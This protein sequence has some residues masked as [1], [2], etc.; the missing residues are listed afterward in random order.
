MKLINY[1]LIINKDLFVS[2]KMRYL[3]FS[4]QNLWKKAKTIAC[5]SWCPHSAVAQQYYVDAIL[6]RCDNL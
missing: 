5:F 2:Y 4:L 3:R 6:D 1:I